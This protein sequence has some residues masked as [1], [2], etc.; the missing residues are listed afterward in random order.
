MRYTFPECVLCFVVDHQP[1]VLN[2]FFALGFLMAFTSGKLEKTLDDYPDFGQ[3]VAQLKALRVQCADYIAEG[4]FRDKLGLEVKNTLAYV[5]DSPKGLGV[6]VADTQN[7]TRKV[8]VVVNPAL[9]G[10]GKAKGANLV[11]C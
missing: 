8:R 11:A 6:I 1:T 5:Y 7:K 4:R 10:H 2:K 3:R 9:V